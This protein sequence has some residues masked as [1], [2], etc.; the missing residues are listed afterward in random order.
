MSRKSPSCYVLSVYSQ[1]TIYLHH[2]CLFSYVRIYADLLLAYSDFVQDRWPT[3]EVV[4]A[5]AADEAETVAHF[6]EML[7][8]FLDHS[9]LFRRAI[10]PL[11]PQ[12]RF[13]S[14][15][16]EATPF[17]PWYIRVRKQGRACRGSMAGIKRLFLSLSD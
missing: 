16:N 1:P 2:C 4:V 7:R 15:R 17:V 6:L 13:D 14:R 10:C 8:R 11:Q 12:G 5:A 9:P 3:A